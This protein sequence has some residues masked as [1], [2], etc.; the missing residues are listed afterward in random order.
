MKWVWL[1]ICVLSS[2]FGDTWSAEGM[3]LRGEIEDFRLSALVHFLHY[4]VTRRL[5][6]AGIV[7]NAISFISFL[8]LLSVAPLS[9]AVPA[10]AIS[11]ILK[12]ALARWYLHEY[13]GWY[14][15]TGALLVAIGVYLLTL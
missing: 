6:V 4:V 11:Y 7:S 5:V 14:R 12:T 2:T 1:M 3:A 13:V 10:T 15:W 8:A 9:F